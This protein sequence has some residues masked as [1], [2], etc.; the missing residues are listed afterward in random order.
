MRFGFSTCAQP[1]YSSGGIDSTSCIHLL[2]R[3]GYEVTGIFV[4]FGQASAV[5]ERRCVDRLSQ[6]LSLPVSIVEA[7]ARQTFGAGEL[8]G[9]NAF[10]IFSALL[11]GGCQNGLL[12]L[13]IHA[14]TPY[15]DCSPAFSERI[16]PL[17]QECTNGRVSLIAPF[18]PKGD[19]ARA[20]LLKPDS[21]SGTRVHLERITPEVRTMTGFAVIGV[22]E[23]EIGN[24]VLSRMLNVARL[25]QELDRHHSDMAC[26][27]FRR[28][29]VRCFDG[30]GGGSWRDGSSHGNSSLRRCA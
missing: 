14:G 16:D 18:V 3:D 5:M 28:P 11:L 22:A 7:S 9:R 12:A 13:G 29:R 1:Y 15:F 30:A 19:H 25:R 10:L 20:L 24:S 8:Q 27:R 2:R 23:K 26:P 4:D 17:V 21:E 6:S